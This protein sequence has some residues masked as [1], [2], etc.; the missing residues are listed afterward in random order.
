MLDSEEFE[1]KRRNN[2]EE[3]FRFIRYWADF[4]RSHDDEEW[5]QQ[6]NV[7]INAQLKSANEMARTGATDPV[8]FYRRRE[9]RA[10][11][12]DPENGVDDS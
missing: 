2:T 8:E 7:L 1:R 11:E 6:Q 10:T 9:A 3:R 5:S 12:L 4:V